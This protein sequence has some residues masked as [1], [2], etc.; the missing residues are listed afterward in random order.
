MLS[1]FKKKSSKSYP[2][3][4]V[5]RGDQE[6]LHL[7][8]RQ[9]R[10]SNPKTKII[11]LG[12]ESNKDCEPFIE[13]HNIKDYFTGADKMAQC[14]IHISPNSYNYELFCIQRHFIMS[15]FAHRHNIDSF[16]HIDSDVLVYSNFSKET[17]LIRWLEKNEV[18]ACSRMCPNLLWFK[19]LDIV[20]ELCDYILKRYSDT[21]FI[22][23]MQED[24]NA[25][26]KETYLGWPID[27]QGIS[28][29]TWLYFFVK[30]NNKKY[31]DLYS[32]INDT[33]CDINL[34]A[35][36]SEFSSSGRIKNVCFSKNIP[37]C[38]LNDG[39]RFIRQHL[40]HFQGH[41][42]KL[43][44]RYTTYDKSINSVQ[45]TPEDV[46]LIFGI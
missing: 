38:V 40:L 44:P 41:K 23:R 1:I 28:D 4:I 18:A 6:Y 13:W 29:M 42:K 21:D 22:N 32:I 5:H 14:Y 20:D 33:Q 17:D 43:M 31:L 27:T 35:S 25:H 11:L 8:L 46:K 15:E 10:H 12:D 7:C 45:F 2:F 16:F 3:I 9:L 19:N 24:V 26:K 34:E 30:D 37:Y 39:P 36:L